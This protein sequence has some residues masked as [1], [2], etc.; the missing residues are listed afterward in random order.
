M[1]IEGQD[2]IYAVAPG[3]VEFT[4]QALEASLVRFDNLRF[5]VKEFCDGTSDSRS[6]MLGMEVSHYCVVEI[7]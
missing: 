3:F 1:L 5:L 6:L 4:V 7:V 2:L